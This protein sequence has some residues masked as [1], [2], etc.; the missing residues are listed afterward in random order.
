MVPAASLKMMLAIVLTLGTT[1]LNAQLVSAADDGPDED[2]DGIVNM[3]DLDDDNDGILDTDEG[4][5]DRDKNGVADAD[6][7]DTDG[8]G[9]VD[10]YDL[11]SD[12]DGILD[13]LEARVDRDAVKALDLIPN[14]AIDISVFVGAN[15]VADVIETSPDSGVLVYPLMD[16]DQ[17]GTPDFRDQDSDND[18]IFDVIEAGAPDSDNNGRIDSFADA[19]GKGV[20]DTIQLSGLPIFDTDGDGQLDF[21]DMDSDGDGISD[22][23]EG[24]GNP[25]KPFDSDNDGAADYRELDSDGD[26]IS[27]ND[28]AGVDLS[29]P[30]DSNGNGIADYREVNS[31][32]S[33]E[34]SNQASQHDGPDRDADGIANQYDLDDDNDGIPDTVEGL[35]DADGNGVADANSRDSDGDG[36]P[37][38][39]DLDSDNDGLLDNREARLDFAAVSALDI[40]VDGAIDISFPVGN[41]GIA[42][43]IETNVDSGQLVYVI[44]DTDSDGTPDYLDTDSDNDGIPDLVE[45]GGTDV[46]SDG[47]IDN[48]FDA[49][50]KGV[51]ESIQAS[52]L[53]VFDTDADG[54]ADYRDTDSDNDGLSDA[55]EAGDNPSN[56]TDTDGDGAADYREQDS[57][58]DGVGDS[59]EQQQVQI[60]IDGSIDSDGDGIADSVD[61]DDDNDGLLDLIEGQE[62]NDGD[63]IIN[64][65]DLDSD[66]DGLFDSL[67][68]AETT[69]LLTDLDNNGDGRLDFNVG[70]NGFVDLLESTLDS[71]T[72]IFMVADSDRDGVPD[73]LDLDSD[74]DSV[75]DSIELSVDTDGD[76]YANF[77]DLDSDQDGLSDLL[78][79]VSGAQDQD[80]DGVLD[81]FVDANF[82]GADDNSASIKPF[83]SDGDGIPDMLD[84]D[85]DGDGVFD[86]IESG[87]VDANDTGRFDGTDDTDG[88]GV[89]DS[90]DAGFTSGIDTDN[91][92]ID[93]MADISFTGGVDT[94][95]DGI[96]D[97]YDADPNG[98]GLVD[99][100][101]RTPFG[102]DNDGLGVLEGVAEAEA[103]ET[104]LNG[105]S[106][107][108]SISSVSGGHGGVSNAKSGFDP[109]FP[110]MLGAAF[111]TL[112]LRMR[113]LRNVAALSVLGLS[114]TACGS[115]SL[116]SLG[117][118]DNYD[119]DFNRR[120]YAGLSGLGSTVEPRTT[121]DR[122]R[123]TETSSAGGTVAL[124]YD[125]SNR[126]SIEGHYSDLG[127]AELVSDDTGD[128]TIGYQ[129]AG[130][131]AII[132]GLNSHEN[133][134]RREGFSV[135]GRLGLGALQ[136]EAEGVEFERLN[137]AHLLAGLGLE[138]GLSNGL[139]VRAE[140]V[141]HETDAK[142]AQLGLVYR[143]GDAD[144]SRPAAVA[145]TVPTLPE[146]TETAPAITASILDNDSDGVP[147][148]LDNCPD[149]AAGLPVDSVGCDELTG[150][151]DGVNFE[152]GS[153]VLTA[154]SQEK[155]AE[156]A[157]VLNQFPAIRVAVAAHTDNQGP[158]ASNLELSKRRAI[159]VARYLVEQ[160]VAGNRLAPQ[161]YGESQ[162]IASNASADGR[163]S[164]RRVE[165][166]VLK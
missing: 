68:A 31:T 76:T 32:S 92:G 82:D 94:D 50:S 27:D 56:P 79:A 12:N 115:L 147:D 1:I 159:S 52:A 37:D 54:I 120:V 145:A 57:N 96:D 152:S 125:I 144:D 63:G 124:G 109:I 47:R 8:D 49:D 36:R 74:N 93:D 142:Y 163:A 105:S 80:N 108:C 81:T 154:G 9:T 70:R 6:S 138:Y 86:L 139:A 128:A 21:R 18:G 155:L 67:E 150:A 4:I 90:V 65:L 48:F 156:V 110:L 51:D 7:T 100:N 134:S 88:N 126:F 111:M 28:E 14:G 118:G 22:L 140:Y 19:D 61:I 103:L 160:G 91:D 41:N 78:E 123:V 30:A 40:K 38:A 166:Q 136:N 165:L 34:S 5:V 98:S 102:D 113:K 121:D 10:G 87:G 69:S 66:G 11:D 158:A 153:D 46:D 16:S 2:G 99:P 39:N 64:S 97:Q 132:Y 157:Q 101:F 44:A 77:R 17:D 107:G 45:A 62:D 58:G 104:G 161:A 75:Y 117:G 24:G 162:P 116:P 73:F 20:S 55:S 3:I 119:S 122:I 133:R 59:Q 72:S 151:I 29:S 131:S 35:I 146:P 112:L 114:L 60:P 42:D 25:S 127:E 148:S 26:G 106:V 33:G 129:V 15:G 164:N 149:T 13:N 130:L 135:F 83:D 95:G 71:G 141:A 43:A 137:D 84:L 85:S 23:V 53:P 143:F 89:P